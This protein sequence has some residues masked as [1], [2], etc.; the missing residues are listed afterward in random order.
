MDTQKKKAFFFSQNLYA[1][2]Q[3][4]Q[5]L[6][7]EFATKHNVSHDLENG[8]C[9]ICLMNQISDG[10]RSRLVLVTL[11][12]FKALSTFRMSGFEKEMGWG[13]GSFTAPCSL[14]KF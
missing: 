14:N 10:R 11:G 9:A 6:I 8:S 4:R 7:K 1:L 3:I 5:Y 12:Y 13:R 2:E